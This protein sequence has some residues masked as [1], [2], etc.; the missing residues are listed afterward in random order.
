MNNYYSIDVY[1][2]N[3]MKDKIYWTEVKKGDHLWQQE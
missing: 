3:K 1:S 2:L